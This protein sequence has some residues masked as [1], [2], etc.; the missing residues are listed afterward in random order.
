MR[1]VID[2]HRLAQRQNQNLRPD[3]TEPGATKNAQHSPLTSRSLGQAV[4]L[5]LG[6]K[7][8]MK[9]SA[10]SDSSQ[11]ERIRTIRSA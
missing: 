4:C 7:A 5:R 8:L 3:K 9:T 10:T 6:T 11:S 2:A 1:L